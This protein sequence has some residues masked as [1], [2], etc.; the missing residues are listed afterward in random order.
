MIATRPIFTKPVSC[1]AL[2]YRRS[3]TYKRARRRVILAKL[4]WALLSVAAFG[5]LLAFTVRL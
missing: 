5:A 1:V 4:G 3:A 2:A